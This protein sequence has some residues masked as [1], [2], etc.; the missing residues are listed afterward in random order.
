MKFGI[1]FEP[2]R[3]EEKSRWNSS[4]SSDYIWKHQPASTTSL[5]RYK[6]V[7]RLMNCPMQ[8]YDKM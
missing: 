6:I 8:I 1:I 3:T 7:T 5:F 2:S 4:Q